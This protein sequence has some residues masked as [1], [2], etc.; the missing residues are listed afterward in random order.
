MADKI[1]LV[2]DEKG[3]LTML[4]NLLYQEGYSQISTA[5]SGNEALELV[6]TKAFD[7]IV[8]DVM[9][10][11]MDGFELCQQ[12]RKITSVPILFLSA[13]TGYL[14]KLMGLGIG[15]DDY[16]TKPFNPL[17]VAARIKAQLRRQQMNQEIYP[18][19]EEILEFGSFQ[20]IK[21]L[22][23]WLSMG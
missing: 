15:G 3:I 2:D 20:F 8:L 7:L 22:D 14:D 16:I 23:N 19:Q 17:E 9:L 13:R 21:V 11:D 18:K 10:P 1:L 4:E 5:T 12:I 6:Q